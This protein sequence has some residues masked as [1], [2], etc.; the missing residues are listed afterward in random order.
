MTFFL[1]LVHFFLLLLSPPPPHPRP[2]PAGVPGSPPQNVQL[3]G[4]KVPKAHLTSLAEYV[5][6]RARQAAE[7]TELEEEKALVDYENV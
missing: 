4:A 6:E 3:H 2:L 1:H 5:E 7:E